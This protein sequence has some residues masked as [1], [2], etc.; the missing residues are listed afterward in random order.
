MILVTSD[1]ISG[2]RIK[3]TLGLVRG[4]CV[5]AKHIG[6]DIGALLKNIVGG[7]LKGYEE[8]LAEARETALERLIQ[9]AEEKGANAVIA[10]RFAT[11]S[12]MSGA[13]EIFAYGTA[14]VVEKEDSI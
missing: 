5:K 4:S 13:S 11:S 1:T 12:I 10:I 3:E 9:D 7:E 6:R 2:Y 8:L 14:V